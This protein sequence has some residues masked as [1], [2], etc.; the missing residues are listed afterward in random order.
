MN[1]TNA[2]VKR[3]HEVTLWTSSFYHQEKRHR[4]YSGQRIK[5]SSQLT[6]QLIPSKGYTRNIGLERLIDHAQLSINLKRVLNSGVDELP[7]V[8]FVGYPPIEVA[9]TMIRWL[10]KRN[11]PTVIDVKDFWPQVFVEAFPVYLRRIAR[12]LLSPYFYLGRQ[13]IARASAVT[14][15]TDSFLS[16]LM[17]FSGRQRS[18][19]DGVLPLSS[20][21]AFHAQHEEE[22]V[23]RL[24]AER[25]LDLSHQRRFIFV[26]SLS[27]AFDFEP[28]YVA[29]SKLQELYPDVELVIC[30]SGEE[31]NN[32]K[33]KFSKFEKVYFPGRI[34]NQSIGFL[35]KHSRATLA[36]YKSTP[37]F[38]KNFPN[39]IIDSL[40]YGVPVI[41][42][43]SGEVQNYI[44]EHKF[45][46]FCEG[47]GDS[48][49][50]AMVSLINDPALQKRMSESALCVYEK[51]FSFDVV[52]GSFVEKLEMIANARFKTR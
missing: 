46:I 3:G 6:I 42:G 5:V 18:P 45:G 36:P 33:E 26:G 29:M 27:R 8:A 38:I 11:I 41:S 12:V 9:H 23:R 34:N 15:M 39:K 21:L 25:G 1:L 7:D 20:H 19:L 37:N 48:W 52:Y 35:M 2:L 49:F 10:E 43:L 4:F 24:W 14:S 31:E 51:I 22:V 47:S 50:K 40:S 44:Q 17:A 30:G 16:E 28:L 13:A 32:L